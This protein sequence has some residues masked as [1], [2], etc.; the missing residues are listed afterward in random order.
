M[1]F[2]LSARNNLQPDPDE[3]AAKI[4]PR[5]KILITNSPGNPTGTVY[6]DEVQR[7][8]AELAVK[9]DLYVLSDEIYARIIY[10]DKF[11]SMLSYP[12]MEERTLPFDWLGMIRSGRCR[13]SPV[14]GALDEVVLDLGMANDRQAAKDYE[15]MAVCRVAVESQSRNHLIARIAGL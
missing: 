8:I 13:C 10:Q 12:G 7:R 1:P 3:I 6:T 2:E 9:H 15:V 11:I 4:A 14:E 5:T